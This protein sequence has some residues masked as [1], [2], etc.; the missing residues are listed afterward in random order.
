MSNF[1][2]DISPDHY[3]SGPASLESTSFEG[4]DYFP[5]SQIYPENID[6]TVPIQDDNAPSMDNNDGY[7]TGET[8][9][10]SSSTAELIHVER[11]H[12]GNT[13]YTIVL[14]SHTDEYARA[15]ETALDGNSLL[16]IEQPGHNGSKPRRDQDPTRVASKAIQKSVD[17]L[18][19]KTRAVVNIDI[20]QDDPR[21]PIVAE[22]NQAAEVYAMSLV[23]LD[24]VATS[25]QRLLKFISATAESH[26]VRDDILHQQLATDIPKMVGDL[27][28]GVALGTMHYR[29][30]KNIDPT[31]DYVS[32][33]ER[34]L[35]TLSSTDLLIEQ[36]RNNE[37]LDPTLFNRALARDYMVRCGCKNQDERLKSLRADVLQNI[38]GT[39]ADICASD[40]TYKEKDLELTLYLRN[41]VDIIKTDDEAS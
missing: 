37:P 41:I 13:T 14:F 1:D 19:E 8:E 3:Q 2:H 6:E 30:L 22:A 35:A 39:V 10:A 38:V 25:S 26:A 20:H 31:Y 40:R 11:L 33:N 27:N 16:A 9:E 28:V 12:S 34:V 15:M 24:P 23:E 4:N 36:T 21:Y 18:A 5:D 29:A 17:R 32:L 7:P